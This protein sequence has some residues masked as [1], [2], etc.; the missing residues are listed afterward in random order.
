V[1]VWLDVEYSQYNPLASVIIKN[2]ILNPMRG[3]PSDQQA[4][5]TSVEKLKKMLEVYDARLSQCKYLAGDF[6]SFADLSHFPSN[7]YLM[8]LQYWSMFESYPHFKAWWEAIMARPS[9]K[10]VLEI[11]SA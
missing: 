9:I 5:D 4:V 8:S 10:K 6:I 1:N 7:F 11:M 3:K 2:V